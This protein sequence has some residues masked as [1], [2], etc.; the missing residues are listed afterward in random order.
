MENM[1][2]TASIRRSARGCFP[3]SCGKTDAGA[4]GRVYHQDTGI[5]EDTRDKRGAGHYHAGNDPARD[6]RAASGAV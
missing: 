2:Y 3:V 4:G 1:P 6:G 5:I